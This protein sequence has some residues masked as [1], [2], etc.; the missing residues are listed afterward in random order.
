MPTPSRDKVL[1]MDGWPGGVNNRIR[2]TEQVVMRQGESIPSSQ[3][4]RKALNVDLTAE[5]HPL[6]RQGYR[7]ETS[8]YAHSAWYSREL[9]LFFVV[10]EGQLRVGPTAN[11][12]VA[13]QNVNRYL[14][15]SY[16]EH[17]GTVY[18]MNGA[19]S[20]SYG[21]NGYQV[22]PDPAKVPDQPPL[23]T[24]VSPMNTDD[25]TPRDVP[26]ADQDD[27]DMLVHD[28]YFE[29]LPIGQLCASHKGRIYV[30]Q[31]NVVYFSEALITDACRLATNLYMRPKYI[32]MLEPAEDG[33]YVA[34]ESSIT[35]ISGTDPF[36]ASQ[37]HVYPHGVVQG[38]FA[39]I[40]G[41]K[42]GVDLRD[43]PV[44]WCKDGTMLLGLPNG[45]IRQLTR[46]RLAVPEFGFGAVS[47]RER[48]G[49]SQVVSS[50]QKGGDE[51]NMGATDTVVAEIR[52]VD[53]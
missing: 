50:L 8:G 26:W 7:Q 2:E 13:V 18:Y 47:L 42:F 51:N 48:E 10:L 28:E 24:D 43:V 23:P 15:M 19:E 32:W 39:R 11:N 30:A 46:D 40:P 6:R 34:D 16:A 25:M 3:F 44:W 33:I 45:Q 1:R 35:F 17:A 9:S 29:T 4:L 22:W 14:H 41:E 31:D 49:I 36:Q 21:A 20:G 5:G 52:R 38:A 53:C 37:V 12:L 27:G